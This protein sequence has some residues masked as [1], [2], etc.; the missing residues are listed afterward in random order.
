MTS[1]EPRQRVAGNAVQPEPIVGWS[2]DV[3][4]SPPGCQVGLGNDIV[5]ITA[6]AEPSSDV[7]AYATDTRFVERP[8][9]RSGVNTARTKTPVV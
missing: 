2:R 1:L 3:I 7:G 4:D 6:S 8:K 9:V 5:S